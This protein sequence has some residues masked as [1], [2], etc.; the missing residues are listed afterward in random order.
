MRHEFLLVDATLTVIILQKRQRTMWSVTFLFSNT[1]EALMSLHS[2]LDE[3]FLHL[4]LRV[5]LRYCCPYYSV[6]FHTEA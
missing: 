3:V 6:S 4:D 2:R 1:E 5:I